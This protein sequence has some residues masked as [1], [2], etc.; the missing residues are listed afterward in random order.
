MGCHDFLQGLP[1]P[2]IEPASLTSP[3]LAGGFFTI[4]A[5]ALTLVQCLAQMFPLLGTFSDLPALSPVAGLMEPPS[6]ISVHNYIFQNPF[7]H[8]F[9]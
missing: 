6:L 2:G 3:A 4:S 5:A 8:F 9:N 1:N 7:K